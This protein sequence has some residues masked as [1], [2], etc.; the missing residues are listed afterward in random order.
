MWIWLD[1]K[2]WD[3]RR[4]ERILETEW[5]SAGCKLIVLYLNK[6]KFYFFLKKYKL[7]ILMW[8]SSSVLNCLSNC[9]RELIKLIYFKKKSDSIN[10]SQTFSYF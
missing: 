10:L 5:I 9:Y 3:K 4:F 8:V 1:L 7:I 6:Q 2:N